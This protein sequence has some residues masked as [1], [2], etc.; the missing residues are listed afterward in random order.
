M[1]RDFKKKT[2]YDCFADIRNKLKQCS[3]SNQYEFIRID[4]LE[5]LFTFFNHRNKDVLEENIKV[6]KK[7]ATIYNYHRE[8]YIVAYIENKNFQLSALDLVKI[9][10]FYPIVAQ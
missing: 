8:L 1:E 4:L 2:L 7:T 9:I 3:Y 10:K 5:C 6:I